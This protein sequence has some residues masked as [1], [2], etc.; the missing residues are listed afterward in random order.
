VEQTKAFTKKQLVAVYQNTEDTSYIIQVC[1][2]Q[3]YLSNTNQP[4]NCCKIFTTEVGTYFESPNKEAVAA[5][6]LKFKYPEQPVFSADIH[7]CKS[8]Y[9]MKDAM[10]RDNYQ[11]IKAFVMRRG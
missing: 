3:L 5:S 6:D 8:M 9:I 2:T 4:F 1:M 7:K 11:N 10:R